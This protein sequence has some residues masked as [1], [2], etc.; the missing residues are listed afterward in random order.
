ME[1]AV[2]DA[3]S[4][5]SLQIP[6]L[7]LHIVATTTQWPFEQKN[8]NDPNIGE[9]VWQAMFHSYLFCSEAGKSV[10]IV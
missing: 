2:S 10:K 8:R 6:G 1:R 5:I 9:S 4:Q 3:T 7:S